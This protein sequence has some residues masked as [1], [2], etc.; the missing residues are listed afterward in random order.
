MINMDL[1]GVVSIRQSEH[2]ILRT[3]VLL[4]AILQQMT[5]ACTFIRSCLVFL[6]PRRLATFL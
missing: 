1:A 6:A 5:L 3:V 4:E 2:G